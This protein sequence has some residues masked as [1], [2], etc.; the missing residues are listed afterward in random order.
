MARVLVTVI[1]LLLVAQT[2]GLAALADEVCCE[3]EPCPPD[4]DCGDCTSC[5][6]Q[7]RVMPPIVAVI[8]PA[9]APVVV[10][11]EPQRTPDEIDPDEI[12]HVPRATA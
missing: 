7:P 8:A 5:V 9:P 6:K 2:A 1:A 3:D 12:L 4:D 10:V 11:S